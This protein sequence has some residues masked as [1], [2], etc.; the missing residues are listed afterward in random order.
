MKLS[1][2]LNLGM[3]R[4]KKLDDSLVTQLLFRHRLSLAYEYDIY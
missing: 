2:V 3:V 4:W 1:V